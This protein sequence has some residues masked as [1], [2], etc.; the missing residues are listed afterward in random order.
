MI[1]F[2]PTYLDTYKMVRI[3]RYNPE[4]HKIATLHKRKTGE[5][6]DIKQYDVYVFV[7]NKVVGY[8]CIMCNGNKCKIHW[9]YAP[10]FGKICFHGLVRMLK[11]KVPNT[12]LL[13]LNCSIDPRE[14]KEVVMRRVN[15]WFGVGCKVVNIT[16]R[17]HGVLL[18]LI[19][20]M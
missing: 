16:Y 6:L 1:F 5:V 15:F 19:F 13:E 7:T 4:I 20:T 11:R 14:N 18:M 9:F 2:N 8:S 12:N 17:E 3:E 10:G